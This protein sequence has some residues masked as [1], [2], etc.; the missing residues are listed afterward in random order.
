MRKIFL[1]LLPILASSCTESNLN[2]ISAEEILGAWY[3][4]FTYENPVSGTKYINLTIRFNENGIGEY[5]H[6]GPTKTTI[7]TFDYT[8]RQNIILCYGYECEVGDDSVKEFEMS[9]KFEEERLVPITKFTRFILTRDGSIVTDEN[10]FVGENN[11]ENDELDNISAP[12]LDKMFT[13]NVYDGFSIFIR[14]NN[15]GDKPSNM[16]C[17]IYWKSYPGKQ[18]QIPSIDELTKIE[19]MNTYT[20]TTKSTTFNIEHAGYNGGT[21]NYYC[22]ECTNRKGTCMTDISYTIV[23]RL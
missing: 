15:N 4:I 20:S 18:S 3:G 21:Y 12:T 22:A 1:L 16:N 23:P 17:T 5:E 13:R 19:E 10:G 7:G 2:S 8:I 11:S 9:L 14:F 6:K